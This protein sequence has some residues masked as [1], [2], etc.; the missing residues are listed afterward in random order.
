MAQKIAVQKL[1]FEKYRSEVT[2]QNSQ[3]VK[4]RLGHADGAVCCCEHVP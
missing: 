2:Q 4:L 1:E 3:L